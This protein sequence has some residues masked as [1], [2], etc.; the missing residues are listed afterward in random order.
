MLSVSYGFAATWVGGG[1]I[2]GITEMVYTPSMGLTWTIIMI[3]AYSASFLLCKYLAFFNC[4][5]AGIF[6]TDEGGYSEQQSYPL[7][8]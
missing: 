5:R 8:F 1:F 7:D 4:M 2:V 3:M 6:C